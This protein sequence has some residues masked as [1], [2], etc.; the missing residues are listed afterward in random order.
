VYRYFFTHTLDSSAARLFGAF[1]GL[2]LPFVFGSPVQ[3]FTPSAG[4]RALSEAMGSAWTSL[5]ATGRPSA[6]GLAWPEYEPASDPYLRFD[7]AL[8]TGAG[9]RTER[10]DFWDPLIAAYTP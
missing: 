4:E 3:G 6:S 9:V 1:H 5:A 10:C 8:S 7:D 2:E